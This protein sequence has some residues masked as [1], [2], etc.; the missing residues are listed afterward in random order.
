MWNSS[1]KRMLDVCATLIAFILSSGMVDYWIVGNTNKRIAV[2][3]TSG[4]ILPQIMWSVFYLYVILRVTQNRTAV[5]R[6]ILSHKWMLWLP[7]LACASFAWSAAP[8]TVIRRSLAL[9]L[10][11]LFG[12]Y[13]AV[14]FSI[15]EQLVLIGGVLVVAAAGSYIAQVFFP[16]AIPSLDGLI[17]AWNGLFADK[18]MLSQ[19]MLFG[20]IALACLLVIQCGHRLL[21]FLGIS[22]FLGLVLLSRSATGLVVGLIT[23]A[24]FIVLRT[25]PGRP[26]AALL[27]LFVVVGIVI[28]TTMVVS[29]HAGQILEQLGKSSTL[30]GRTVIWKYAMLSVAKRPI[31]GYGY[32]TFWHVNPESL[33]VRDM[34]P[35]QWDTP[36]AHDSY[37]ETMLQLG[38]VGLG[39]L[40]ITFIIVL[41][42][43]ANLYFVRRNAEGI[44]PLML[45]IFFILTGVDESFFLANNTLY[46]FVFV[47]A[48]FATYEERSSM[49]AS[50]EREFAGV[51]GERHAMEGA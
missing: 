7:L 39:T 36:G 31:L 5:I 1:L 8:L 9:A 50:G 21:I 43:S 44:W 22:L 38:L 17:G 48:A 27:W 24:C 12:V 26:K 32:S 34:L 15:R 10:T 35:N 25:F 19:R 46:W 51:E 6:K 41:K 11:Y 28:T 30:T 37:I 49:H 20:A 16:G 23:I 14:K 2:T 47:A 29:A 42:R 13:V 40:A 18:N 45:M 33:H 4:N 3:A